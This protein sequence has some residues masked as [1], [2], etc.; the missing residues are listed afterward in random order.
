MFEQIINTEIKFCGAEFHTRPLEKINLLGID[1]KHTRQYVTRNMFDFGCQNL[2][3]YLLM[4]A[5]C[6]DCTC[7]AQY[8]A[9]WRLLFTLK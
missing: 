4:L 7:P 1:F 3:E 9:P 6:T 2:H 5:Y 8:M